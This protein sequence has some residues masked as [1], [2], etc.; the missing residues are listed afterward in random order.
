MLYDERLE[1]NITQLWYEG[2]AV[3]LPTWVIVITC[4]C[5]SSYEHVTKT[6]CKKKNHITS[7]CVILSVCCF[8]I[9]TENIL[10]C[11]RTK[12]AFF[13]SFF[14]RNKWGIHSC[15]SKHCSSREGR[16]FSRTWS[17][18]GLKKMTFLIDLTHCFLE[19]NTSI[20]AE[21]LIITLIIQL[22]FLSKA[23]TT[24]R[25]SIFSHSWR[26]SSVAAAGALWIPRMFPGAF[27]HPTM[28]T[29]HTQWITLI[30]MVNQCP[31]PTF[32]R[33]CSPTDGLCVCSLAA[34]HSQCLLVFLASIIQL[35]QL[36]LQYV[37]SLSL[38]EFPGLC[39]FS[40]EMCIKKDFGWLFQ[41]FRKGCDVYVI[42]LLPNVS[43]NCSLSLQ[44]KAHKGFFNTRSP[45]IFTSCSFFLLD[46]ILK[47]CL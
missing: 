6:H 5:N 42:T 15:L 22:D 18:T 39:K 44:K 12:T 19:L 36:I 13:F 37:F 21:L 30:P 16:L 8:N 33:V 9:F 35:S 27:S 29:R 38:V 20:E 45:K 3:G 47:Y 4:L 2:L 32:T 23:G 43:L 17:I 1:M 34:P 7:Y 26:V 46:A 28:V 41:G 25:T 31:P 11:F 10:C 40:W 24:K 14:D